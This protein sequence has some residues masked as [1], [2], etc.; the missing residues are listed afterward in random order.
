MN[1]YLQ[2]IFPTLLRPLPWVMQPKEPTSGADQIKPLYPPCFQNA[3]PGFRGGGVT[4]TN[5]P[6]LTQSTQRLG[7]FHPAGP[8]GP[9]AGAC[10][11]PGQRH[12]VHHGRRRS[13]PSDRHNP[14]V[15]AGSDP[16]DGVA[17]ALPQTR[18]DTLG[19]TQ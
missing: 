15:A 1:L 6:T 9:A 14:T 2:P 18:I 19:W 12:A 10:P 11:P 3:G 17:H 16:M 8:D 4:V 13:V 5:P 7:P